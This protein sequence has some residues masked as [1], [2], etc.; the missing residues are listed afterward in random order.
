MLGVVQA[1]DTCEKVQCKKK[2]FNFETIHGS[3]VKIKDKKFAS[4]TASKT[5]SLTGSQEE[6]ERS[7][8]E[9]C[10]KEGKEVCRSAHLETFQSEDTPSTCELFVENVYDHWPSVI[11]TIRTDS[12]GWTSFHILVRN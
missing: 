12:T 4:W 8:S 9:A 5:L 3:L 7:C 2:I 1:Q 11:N 10:V 6:R